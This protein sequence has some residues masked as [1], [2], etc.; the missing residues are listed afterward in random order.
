VSSG[1]DKQTEFTRRIDQA[2]KFGRARNTTLRDA[3]T[4]FSLGTVTLGAPGPVWLDVSRVSPLGGHIAVDA[5]RLL[6]R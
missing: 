5:V 6:R 1:V 2:A 3:P 4:W